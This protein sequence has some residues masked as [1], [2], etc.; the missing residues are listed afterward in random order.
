MTKH[1]KGGDSMA[2]LI[3][4]AL[5]CALQLLAQEKKILVAYP[6]SELMERLRSVGTQARI[7]PVT[8]S[9]VMQEITDADAFIGEITSA[10]VRAGKNLKWV[11]VMSAGVERVLFP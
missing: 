5:T 10:E 7:V 9:N 8:A 2:R 1:R 11:G 6:D 3:F 4:V